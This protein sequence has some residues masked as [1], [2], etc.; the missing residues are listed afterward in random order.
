MERFR[1]REMPRQK[2]EKVDG[3]ET[4]KELEEFLEEIDLKALKSIF[5]EINRQRG[6]D[7]AKFTFQAD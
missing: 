3:G 2:I 5:E 4:Q 6:L 7:W 1:R